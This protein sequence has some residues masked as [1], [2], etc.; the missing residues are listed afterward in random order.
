MNN[1]YEILSHERV[2]DI[3]SRILERGK[4]ARQESNT[5]KD[6]EFEKGRALAYYEVADILQS[7]LR[8]DGDLKDFGLDIDLFEV[9]M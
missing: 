3:V 4:E 1:D 9:L 8:L 2:R 7:E 5:N 6:D